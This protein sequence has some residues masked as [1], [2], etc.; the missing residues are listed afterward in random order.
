MISTNH[1][2]VAFEAYLRAREVGFV[3][4]N[5]ARRTF[6]GDSDVKSLDFIVVG[7]ED[8]KL[9]VDVKGRRFPGGTPQAPRFV[10]QNWAENDDIDGLARWAT[11]F[12]PD[13]RG[14]LA[15][16]YHIEPP[17]QLPADTP[18]LFAFRDAK[19]LMRA[20]E[21]S[22]YRSRMRRRSPRW[23]TVG[24]SVADFREVVKPFSTFLRPEE[25]PQPVPVASDR[26]GIPRG[27]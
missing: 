3:S 17:F 20:V 5:E 9:V 7:P 14:I 6:L 19:Y 27:L 15:F 16:A 23:G 25:S 2:E 24:L 22:V 18:D 13:F 12:G 21:V 26:K 4:V 10:W 11:H 1:Y 8:A